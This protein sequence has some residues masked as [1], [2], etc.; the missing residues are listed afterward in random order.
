MSTGNGS[1]VA[2]VK[3]AVI[4]PPRRMTL[5]AVKRGKVEQPYRLLVHG[6]DGV[7]KTTFA[8]NAPEPIFVAAEAGTDHLDVASFRDPAPATWQDVL[9]ATR[10]LE[11]EPHSYKTVVYDSVDWMEPLLWRSVCT[12]AGVATMED[13]GGGFGKGYQAA[14]DGWRVFLAAVERMQ[15]ARKVNVI[16]LGHS[17][18]K[19]FKNPQGEDF[20]RYILKLHE[21]SAALLREWC[22]GVYFAN[23]EQFADKDLKTKRI[24]G[25]STGARLL[26]TQ[27]TAAYDAKDRYGLPETFALDWSEFEWRRNAGTEQLVALVEE[28]TRKAKEVGGEVEKKSLDYLVKNASNATQL[29]LLNTKLNAKL[30]EKAEAAPAAPADAAP[31]P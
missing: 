9:D 19:A 30:A 29:Q 24:R 8:A 17:F 3:P 27:R 25:I 1:A 11:T 4:V 28:I 21:K 10:T 14:L 31:A 2:A 7:G 16:L 26:Y 18:I 12:A 5:A 6:V 20:D 15:A 23:Y 13:V 22:G